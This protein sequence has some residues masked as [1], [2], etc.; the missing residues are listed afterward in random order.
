MPR[1][2][3]RRRPPPRA[4]TCPPTLP[5]ALLPGRF[6]ALACTFVAALLMAEASGSP[7]ADASPDSTHDGAHPM[8]EPDASPLLVHY[9]EAYLR[10]QE[11]EDFRLNVTARY[12]EG[13][14]ARLARSPSPKA[15][16]AAVLA[17]GLV[18]SYEINAVVARSLR[19]PDPT[20]RNLANS[21][22]WAI[23]FRADS[24]E[25][26][27]TLEEV[28][29]LNNRRKFAEAQDL[30]TRLIDRA[31]K[32]AEAYN[33]RAIASFFRGR[34]AESE[35]DCRRALELNP[36]HIGAL[37]GLGQCYLRL[38]RRDEALATFRRALKLQPFSEGLRETVAALEAD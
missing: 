5:P 1:P 32:F 31:P 8:P 2:P 35:A 38:E 9:F 14:L 36:Y 23:W 18:G 26:N 24:P 21:A 6:V 27:A 4:M 28:H 19:D 25:N 13:S 20:V 17:L 29:D 12:T 30:A 33:Q 11:I 16:R 7:R 10:D 37:A 15:R 3:T 34:F 22:L